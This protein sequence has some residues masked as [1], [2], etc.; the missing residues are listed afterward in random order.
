MTIG[1]VVRQRVDHEDFEKV[2]VEMLKWSELST[3][4]TFASGAANTCVWT[5]QV[6]DATGANVAAV[7]NL[8]A[9]FSASSAGAGVTGVTYSGD[10]VATTGTVLAEFVS[11]KYFDLL[12]DATGKFVGVLT[13][14]AKTT[15]QYLVIPRPR[16]DL[17]LAGPTVTGSYG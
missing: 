10:L 15:G 9:Y 12:T 8:S 16:G 13:D 14:T 1:A 3:T 11:K 4:I 6:V 7:F 2:L 5:V 17:Q